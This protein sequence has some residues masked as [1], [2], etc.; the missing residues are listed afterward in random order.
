MEASQPVDLVNVEVAHVQSR[1]TDLVVAHVAP[2]IAQ[3][4]NAPARKRQGNI[5]VQGG[6]PAGPTGKE[7]VPGTAATA[8]SARPPTGKMSKVSG[9]KRK[10]VSTKKPSS[11]PS[12]PARRSRTVP[13]YGAASTAGEVFDERAES[14][15]SNNAIAEFVNL[16][17]PTPST[18][19]KPRS[20][21]SITR[22]W[23]VAW[24]TTTVK[25][26]RSRCRAAC[27]E[28][29]HNA[30]L[31]GTVEFDYEKIAQQRYI[32]MEASE[33]KKI[34]LEH[35]WEML[36]DCDKWKLIDRESPSKRGS[37]TNMDEDEDD[38]SRNLNKHDG[39]KKTKEKIK[40]EHEASTL[41]D[42][43]DTM[44]QSN[45]VLLAKSL[46][47]KIEL[48]EKNARDKQERPKLLKDV[49]ERRAR[50]AE[51]K[52]MANLLAEENSIMTLNRN[53]MDDINK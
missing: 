44:V 6:I 38:G 51:N 32:G 19:I 9:V 37:L 49:E 42:K 16:L 35:C 34:K 48:S 23:R 41:R 43:I 45:E 39:D 17:T 33:G 40:R 22:N 8:R 7:R 27:L 36:K 28:Q 18:S 47:A 1:L 29:V 31:S 3:G 10:K 14:G 12:A 25:M 4:T 11:T 21:V 26:K 53:G 30:P 2:A 24:M 52:T 13:L 5:L 46:E 15:G 50:A 20:L